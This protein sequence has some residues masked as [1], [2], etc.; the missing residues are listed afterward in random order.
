[1]L[2]SEA[3]EAGFWSA[4]EEAPQDEVPRLIF[5]DW[6]EE[7]N[8]PRGPLLRERPY[9]RHLSAACRDPVQVVLGILDAWPTHP[10][11][12]LLQAAALVGAPL[13]PGLLERCRAAR[14]S[15]DAGAADL[16]AAL[17]SDCLLPI[18]P[19]LIDLLPRHGEA[20]APALPRLGPAA[21]AAV[22]A[23]LEA[24]RSRS[25]DRQTFAKTI[26]GIG[27]AAGSPEVVVRL[28]DILCAETKHESRSAIAEALAVIALPCLEA[29]LGTVLQLAPEHFNILAWKLVPQTQARTQA[30]GHPQ[31]RC[32]P[33]SGRRSNSA[34]ERVRWG[35]ACALARVSIREALPHLLD[36]LRRAP[37]P[38]LQP[39]V[40]ALHWPEQEA[41]EALPLLRELLGRPELPFA[42]AV[43]QSLLA[44]SG[45][46]AGEAVAR[47]GDPDPLV[48]QRIVLGVA[49]HVTKEERGRLALVGALL[50]P[51]R[52]RAPVGRGLLHSVHVP[53]LGGP[54]RAGPAPSGADRLRPPG[55]GRG[56][57]C[58]SSSETEGLSGR[59][60][61]P[62][63][64]AWRPGRRGPPQR[65]TQPGNAGIRN[66]G[67]VRGSGGGT[68]RPRR[69]SAAELRLGAVPLGFHDRRARSRR[70]APAGPGGQEPG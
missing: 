1:M 63:P 20:L 21:V 3:E 25:L 32:R 54:G 2:P 47:L 13:V 42:A 31:A 62:R 43:A 8:D 29:V 57:Q 12:R 61:S 53:V 69:G 5:A 16:L 23:L 11:Q 34:D 68:G 70:A 52:Q 59:A 66:A 51:D 49:H 24:E 58:P 4:I 22:P 45:D 41:A 33:H 28:V 67:H 55:A 27:P 65:R 26:V 17:S 39:V 60:R 14:P 36:A 9:W 48:R 30:T 35:A 6:L 64:A 15:R 46:P 18:L 38:M 44:I 40:V 19:D 56:G 7:R 10:G 37:L 50:D